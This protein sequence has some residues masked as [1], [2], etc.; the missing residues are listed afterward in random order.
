MEK[1]RTV[2]SDASQLLPLDVELMDF[3]LMPGRREVSI[4]RPAHGTW[5][6][7][8]SRILNLTPQ[9]ALNLLAWLEMKR[10]ELETLAA[11]N[12]REAI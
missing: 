1:D 6:R 2:I 10:T 12:S 4:L 9:T 11:N 8:E 7:T 3:K 5:E